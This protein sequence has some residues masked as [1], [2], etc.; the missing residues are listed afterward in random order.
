MSDA[1][2][3][4][5]AVLTIDL[6]AI[7]DNWR[8]LVA[9]LRPGARAAA[10]VK[11]DAYGLGAA[12]VAPALAA[13]GCTRFCTATL[14]EALALRP[15]LPDADILV[16]S[17]PFAGTEEEFSAHRLLPV[18]N[19]PEQVAAWAAHAR[20]VGRRLP[21][22][23]HVDTGLSRL[24]LGAAEARALAVDRT[25]FGAFEAVLLISHLAIAEEPAD[26]M[27]RSQFDRFAEAR[28]LFPGVPASLAASSG[29]FLGPDWH[30]DWVRP[31]ASLYGVNPTPAQPNPM[32]QV[33]ELKGRIILVRDIDAGQT[34]GYGATWRA[35]SKTRLAVVAAGYADGMLRSLANRG[36][37]ILGETRVPLVGR[38]SMDL[39]VFDVGALPAA[40]ARAGAFVT[41]I[42]EGNTVDQVGDAAATIGYEILTHLGRRYLREWRGSADAA[43]RGI[44]R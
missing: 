27:N 2:A 29:I 19:S 22:A 34:V 8:N 6:D 7:V 31:G 25:A 44:A 28:A 16:F 21:A 11:A 32:K 15:L 42:G 37:A 23:L 5:G 1:A 14:D 26:P 9:R 12:R 39:M 33:I 10:V 20:R 43:G 36:S 24:G 40:A 4:A 13:A 18:L 30:L 3:R 38:V 35:T 17:G 41:L